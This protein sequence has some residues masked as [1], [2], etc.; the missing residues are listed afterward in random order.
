MC[1]MCKQNIS[2]ITKQHL[3]NENLLIHQHLLH[4]GVNYTKD[5]WDALL[6]CQYV[7]ERNAED[8]VTGEYGSDDAYFILNT[9]I[10]FEIAKNTKL[11][12]AINNILDRD[13]YCSD[14]TPGRVYSVG[15]RYSF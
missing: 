4:A 8:T 1:T 9:A 14:M 3:C 12:F 10:N 15:L 6:E 7:T 13:F 11:Q 2:K 5:K